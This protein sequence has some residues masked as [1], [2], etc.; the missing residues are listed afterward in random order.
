LRWP[1]Y[2]E[3]A[4]EQEKVLIVVQVNGKVRGK[5][6]VSSDVSSE[7]VESEALADPKISAFL[8]GKRVRRT[9][10]VP[11]RLINIVMEG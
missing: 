2:S 6:T 5:L 8:Q 4:L 11:K 1:E 10:Y 7:A 3:D 9:V